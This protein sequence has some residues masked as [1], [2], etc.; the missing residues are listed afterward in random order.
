MYMKLGFIV[1]GLFL[2]WFGFKLLRSSKFDKF[3]DDIIKGKFDKEPATKET[4]KD[5][6]TAEKGLGKQAEVNIKES[7]KL[8]KESE[9]I[10]N[11]LGNRV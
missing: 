4:M 7:E 1:L 9:G 5:I 8:T 6:T 10:N 11:F 3:C 2:T